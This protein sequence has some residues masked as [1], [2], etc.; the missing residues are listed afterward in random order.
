MTP[1]PVW[2]S[3]P[4]KR[5]EAA[6]IAGVGTPL[7]AALGRTWRWRVEGWATLEALEA[8]AHPPILALW[9]GRI[10]SAAILLKHRGVV[11][12]ASDNFDGQW[13][14]TILSRF[15]YGIARGSSSRGGVKA[16]V[17]L[18]RE[19]SRGRTTAFTVDG[20]RGPI[21]EVQP[22]CLW[23]AKTTGC[24]ILPFHI[25]AQR[26]WTASSWDQAQIPK[27]FS[28]VVAC[29]G[30]PVVVPADLTDAGLEA[31]RQALE[32]RMR[33]LITHTVRLAQADRQ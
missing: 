30:E 29:F 19:A 10:L 8:A 25:E 28:P 24:P 32:A 22:G 33:D 5:V 6:A 2:R 20:P 18:K 1:S 3:S 12:L 7:I 21:Y 11:A 27:P 15:G 14:A 26:Y 4:R 13:I 16:L 9:H 31:Y 23:L 17:R